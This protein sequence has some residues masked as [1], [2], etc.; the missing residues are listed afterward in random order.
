MPQDLPGNRVRVWYR[1]M[2]SRD[3]GEPHRAATPL[4]LLFDLCFV[5]A[6]AQAAVELHHALTENHIGSGLLSFALVFY[7]IWWGWLNFTWFASAFDTDDVPYRLATMVQIAGGLVVA[8]GVSEAFKGDFT[9][10]AIGYVIM[11]LAMVSQWLRA[12]RGDS[13]HRRTALRYALGISVVQVLWIGRLFLPDSLAVVTFFVLVILES[14]VPP[15]A[16]RAG[17]TT[18]HPHH[19][20]ERYGL[21]TIIVLGESILSATMAIKEGMTD[22]EHIGAL[23]SLA[24]AGL[25][26][27]FG[28]WWLYFDQ[29]GH[30]RITRRQTMR[31]TVSWGYGHYLIFASAAAVG[32]GI[33]VAV[34]YD[35]D[36]THLSGIV[37]AL[38]TTVAVAVFLL[39]V[40][41]LHIGPTN[42]CRPI[43]IG[44]PVAA[45]L[46]LAAS[47]TPAPIHVTAVLVAAL[48]VTTVLA[49]RG[50]PVETR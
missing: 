26:I 9:V 45:L 2:V 1:P 41:L 42:E 17:G 15:I 38:P 50:H 30:A 36:A 7:A 22:G 18:W 16:E 10:I 29:P 14:S 12:A 48:V 11:R 24:G 28:M 32:A 13:A 31:T 33:E 35:T 46:V 37:A 6:V 27:V 43:A 8:A 19:I 39:S 5:V 44:F 47:F 23:A 34:D 25:V 4:E 21:F 49:T 40:W 20:A 3:S